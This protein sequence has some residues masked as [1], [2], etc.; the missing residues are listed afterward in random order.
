MNTGIVAHL[1]DL[2]PLVIILGGLILGL[3]AMIGKTE[4]TLLFIIALLPLRN[5]VE[6][7]QSY[8]FGADF[9]DLLI[10]SVF[11]GS[12]V[13]GRKNQENS[14]AKS[15]INAISL[16]MIFYLFITLIMGSYYLNQSFSFSIAD[17]RVQT[18]KNFCTLPLLYFLTLNNMR[19]K[20]WI[21]RT[22]IVMC[23]TIMFMNNFQIRQ[24]SMYTNLISRSKM[25]GTFVYL[26]VNE[27][28][29]FYNMYTVVL[30]GLFF[31]VKQKKP[32]L[33]LLI[34][35]ATNIFC[36]TFMFSRAAYLGLAVGMF[37]LLAMKKKVLLVFLVIMAISGQFAIPEKVKQRIRET[38]NEHGDLD[39]SSERR[40]NVWKESID[41]FL[42]RPLF[43]YGYGVF[44]YMGFDLGDTHN[45]YLK[46]LVE[47]GLGGM[48]I[49][50]LLILCFF[51]IGVRLYTRGDD[52]LS[53]GLGLGFS[54]SILV[55]LVNNMFGD[56]WT[57][58]E[59][60]SYLW[61]F[62]GLVSRL[63]ILSSQQTIK[64]VKVKKK[65]VGAVRGVDGPYKV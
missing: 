34:L 46:I 5:V 7:L 55:L 23:A 1:K 57:Y 20:K 18:W 43:G 17:P 58:A 47:Q 6:K 15:P 22:V 19:D 2:A 30:T 42:E 52:D 41:L 32:K 62:A 9:L 49:F 28:A 50:L 56:R 10:L 45:I 44:P 4:W 63:N 37:V 38:T 51:F 40:L 64:S 29:A 33:L 11:I 53:K 59:V 48:F 60:S 8:R 27:V 3:R 12:L 14:L 13:R 36:I 31:Y 16:I 26:G 24:V 65:I 25:H 54:V 39:Q 35:I 21:W 61:V